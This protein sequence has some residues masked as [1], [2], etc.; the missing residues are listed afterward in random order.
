L[1]PD[2]FK[3]VL[4]EKYSAILQENVISVVVSNYKFI[5][6]A[7]LLIDKISYSKYNGNATN[8]FDLYRMPIQNLIN[9]NKELKYKIIQFILTDSI[10]ADCCNL[11]LLDKRTFLYLGQ[12]FND[13]KE[14]GDPKYINSKSACHKYLLLEIEKNNIKN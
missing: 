2:I 3:Y 12:L 6:Y 9:R 7:K 4:V 14:I 8:G 5:D 11:N 1:I 10:W 13:N